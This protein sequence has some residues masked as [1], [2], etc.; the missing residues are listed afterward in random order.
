MI[1]TGPAYPNIQRQADSLVVLVLVHGY[2]SDGEA[3]WLFPPG[4]VGGVGGI[5]QMKKPAWLLRIRAL[6]HERG[7]SPPDKG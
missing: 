1:P 3:F 6:I 2:G 4:I 7:T 5:E